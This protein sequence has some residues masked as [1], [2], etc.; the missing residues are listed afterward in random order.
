M[1]VEWAEPL[2]FNLYEEE[3][4]FL[5]PR[6]AYAT[7][8]VPAGTADKYRAAEVWKDFGNIEEY[9]PTG[10][11]QIE[12]DTPNIL[13]GKYLKNGRVVIMKAGK[14]YTLDGKKID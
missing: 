7:L 4:I 10:I 2:E 9:E 13:N 1:T 5:T 12:N 14:E 3:Q 11:Q 6:L 8:H